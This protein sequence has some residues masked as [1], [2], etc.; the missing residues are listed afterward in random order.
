MP[1][2]LLGQ[3]RAGVGLVGL[4][5]VAAVLDRDG[6]GLSQVEVE[7]PQRGDLVRGGEVADDRGGDGAAGA[8]DGDR[9]QAEISSFAR[10]ASH[11]STRSL[12]RPRSRPVS[13]STR[14]IR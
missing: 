4:G 7:Q 13:S 12:A 10:S 5:L 2:E 6:L 11:I 14:L 8:D 9:T 1:V 3:A